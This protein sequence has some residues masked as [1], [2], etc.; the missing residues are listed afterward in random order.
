M[1]NNPSLIEF[2]CQ[3][4]IKIIGKNTPHFKQDILSIA[5]RHDPTFDKDEAQHQMSAQGKYCSFTLNV[6]VKDQ[7]SLDQ[8][9][10][11]L[12]QHPDSQMVL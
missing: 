4:P 11:E 1:K 9:Y 2:P 5:Q 10:Q 7:P 3:F 12:T 8:L 6:Y